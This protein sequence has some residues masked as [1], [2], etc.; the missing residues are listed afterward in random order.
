MW[1]NALK[2]ARPRPPAQVQAG[3]LRSLPPHAGVGLPKGCTC[4]ATLAASFVEQRGTPPP[5]SQPRNVAGP[6]KRSTPLV[7]KGHKVEHALA[8]AVQTLKTPHQL[9]QFFVHLLVNDSVPSPVAIWNTFQDALAQD[10]IV[11][12]GNVN[13]GVNEALQEIQRALGEHGKSLRRYGLP[14]PAFHS[15][16]VEVELEKWK[17][18]LGTLASRSAT[19]V[20]KLN[21][22]QY[23]IYTEIMDAVTHRRPLCAFVDGKAGRGKTFLVNTICNK[24]R[25]AG[26][27]V[28]PTA[29]S[30][31]AA[32]LYPGG[33]TTHSVFKVRALL[34]PCFHVSNLSVTLG[35]CRRGK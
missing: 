25:A 30:A 1:K 22:E 35:T 7:S 19:A 33:K 11:E 23:Q 5:P 32:Q 10:F 29:T 4:Y 21:A 2:C 3:R 26:H 15:R 27:I 8:E 9:R 17:P 12:S 28:L 20:S 18:E 6:S 16:E 24:L 13:I 14:E 31:F 34:S